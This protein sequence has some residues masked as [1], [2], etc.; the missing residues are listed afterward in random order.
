MSL[1]VVRRHGRS[2]DTHLKCS[3]TSGTCY[4]IVRR[5]CRYFAHWT[6]HSLFRKCCWCDTF[7]LSV[8]FVAPSGILVASEITA[9]RLWRPLHCRRQKCLRWRPHP[10]AKVKDSSDRRLESLWLDRSGP[11]WKTK[12]VRAVTFSALLFKL[13]VSFSTCTVRSIFIL[14]AFERIGVDNWWR[15]FSY[16]DAILS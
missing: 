4:V 1:C 7:L 15:L 9:L 10:C 13:C 8:C 14:G 16:H 6:S 3:G 12:D 2:S 5:S 11:L